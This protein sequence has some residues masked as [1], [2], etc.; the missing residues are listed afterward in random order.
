MIR[1]TLLTVALLLALA[2]PSQ[3][4]VAYVQSKCTS[5][6]ASGFSVAVTLDAAVGS[7]NAVAIGVLWFATTD[8]TTGATDDKSNTFTAGDAKANHGGNG[9]SSKVFYKGNLT[10]APITFTVNFSGAITY[11]S[12]CVIEASGIDT[13]TALRTSGSQTQ[14]GIGTG[15]DAISSGNSALS[16][17]TGDFVIGFT[18]NSFDWFDG[19]T[20]FS[21][22]TGYT[23]PAG[24]AG[25]A[26]SASTYPIAVE[27]K[28]AGST[29]AVAATFT[30]GVGT[31]D[32]ATFVLVFAQGAGGG[33]A[34]PKRLL[35]LG[36]CQP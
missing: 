20:Y 30:H 34:A 12:M 21:G 24:A 23:K 6:S 3:G 11:H 1:R 15:T 18:M 27:Y 32:A 14:D 28:T 16:A 2:S 26:G 10:N 31:D 33:A 7:G 13:T 5:N 29:A 25:A 17:T 9:L 22:G 4:A 8:T 35:L 36:C 19:T